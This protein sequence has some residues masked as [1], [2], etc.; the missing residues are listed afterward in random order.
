[1]PT[2]Y[3]VTGVTGQVARALLERAP[4]EADREICAIGRPDLD[5]A[6]IETIEPALRAAR[7]DVIL[8]CAAY[9]A[10]DQAE[11]EEQTAFRINAEAVGEIGRVAKDLG[12]PV[13]HLSTDYVFDGEKATPYR[14]DDAVNALGAYG[15]S[16]LEGERRLRD[17]GADHVILRTAWVYSPF[18]KNFLK[19]MLTLAETR[20]MISVVGDQ[21][22][23]PTSALDIADAMVKV[24]E[25]LLSSPASN[26]RGVFHLTATGSASWAEF[27]SEIFAQ[28]S[29]EGG[30]TA[31]VRP[32]STADYPT[33]ARRPKNSRLDCGKLLAFHTIAMP[34]W[35]DS[36]AVT[37]KRLL[38]A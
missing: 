4:A 5:L 12:V 22:G 1:M 2:R 25:N 15:R 14:E 23:N 19:T 7:P 37:L 26:L 29:K 31:A 35:Q 32:I 33:K 3:V 17:S 21:F 28:S 11:D 24:G 20:D 30:P 8:S 27:A 18:G 9:T 16:K 34:D 13:I 36:V 10:V 6:R 38:T